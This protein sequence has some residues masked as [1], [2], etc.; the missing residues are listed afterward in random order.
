MKRA[1]AL[2][3]TVAITF[4]GCG[5]EDEPE[6]TP[7]ATDSPRPTATAAGTSID[8]EVTAGEVIGGMKRVRV[9]LGDTVALAVRSDVADEVH[10][11]GIEEKAEIPAGGGILMRFVADAPGIFV[12]EFEE[13]GLHILELE[14]R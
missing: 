5:G 8:V 7:N 2:L 1:G 3:L 13:R 14:V 11:H 9:P 10:V 12:V 4:A 6:P